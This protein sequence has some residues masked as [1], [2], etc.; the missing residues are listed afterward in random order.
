MLDRSISTYFSY[1]LYI[2]KI[3]LIVEA[4]LDRPRESIESCLDYSYFFIKTNIDNIEAKTKVIKLLKL[5]GKKCKRY[6]YLELE[7]KV[8]L[9]LA[10]R[11]YSI[12]KT[13]VIKLLYIK[14][15][16]EKALTST[17]LLVSRLASNYF[18][19][20]YLVNTNKKN[21]ARVAIASILLYRAKKK[22][23]YAVY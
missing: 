12:A 13:L 19:K 21:L 6:Y 11:R 1:Y 5:L 23:F 15:L 22:D 4:D 3:Y 8:D 9:Q 7:V 18:L 16:E 10:L 20:S 2:K 17:I 14:N